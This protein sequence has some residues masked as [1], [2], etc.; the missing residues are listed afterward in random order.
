MSLASVVRKS[1]GPTF[2]H[3]F[4]LA[5]RDTPVRVT[6]HRGLD[7]STLLRAPDTPRRV[8]NR[9]RE[10]AVRQQQMPGS[11]GVSGTGPLKGATVEHTPSRREKS[12][13]PGTNWV[14]LTHQS[15]K[16]QSPTAT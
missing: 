15:Q 14:L 12:A 16:W 9:G 10:T 7:T 13:T 4:A 6:L 2:R 11:T 5:L 1:S 3:V 8:N